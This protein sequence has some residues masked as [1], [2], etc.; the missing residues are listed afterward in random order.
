[1]VSYHVHLPIRGLEIGRVTTERA[2]RPGGSGEFKR[3][4]PP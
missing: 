3:G 2:L 1:M 4:R